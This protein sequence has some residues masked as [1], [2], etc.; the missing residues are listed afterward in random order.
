MVGG[1]KSKK[2]SAIW[3]EKKEAHQLFFFDVV[4][5]EKG[6]LNLAFLLPFLLK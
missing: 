2:R 4:V 6:P 5:K 1:V 3:P